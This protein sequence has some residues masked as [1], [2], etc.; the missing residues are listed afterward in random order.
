MKAVET[1]QIGTNYEERDRTPRKKK[2]T[3][4]TE[5]QD[6]TIETDG[7]K[8]NKRLYTCDYEHMHTS[9]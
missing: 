2:L 1:K 7:T 6:E 5:R 8:E 3:K 9:K 4:E